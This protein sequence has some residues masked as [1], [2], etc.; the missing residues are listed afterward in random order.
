[1]A[2]SHIGACRHSRPGTHVRAG[3]GDRWDVYR[4]A[5]ACRP[6]AAAGTR[7]P[8]PAGNR[9]TR[10][11]EVVWASS[12]RRYADPH[13][14]ATD[15]RSSE[16]SEA[17]HARSTRRTSPVLTM[18]LTGVARRDCRTLR[19]DGV[20][21][22][23]R[24]EPISGPLRP[25]IRNTGKAHRTGYRPRPRQRSDRRVTTSAS[26]YRQPARCSSWVPQAG[27]AAASR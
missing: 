10:T 8:S 3:Q 19:V 22:A 26:L 7:T 25:R 6:L 17:A 24:A 14:E 4:R 18:C 27:V 16:N 21:V 11:V 12:G 9:P 1:M 23:S 13:V 20:G 2:Q 15:H 5:L